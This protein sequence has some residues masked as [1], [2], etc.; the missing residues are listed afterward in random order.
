MI[1]Y[2]NTHGLK[3]G[4][5]KIKKIEKQTFIRSELLNTHFENPQKKKKTLLKTILSLSVKSLDNKERPCMFVGV[6]CYFFLLYLSF[7]VCFRLLVT[8]FYSRHYIAIYTPV[9]MHQTSFIGRNIYIYI[10]ISRISIRFCFVVVFSFCI[11]SISK[12]FKNY[13]QKKLYVRIKY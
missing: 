13:F 3:F 1:F 9:T 6:L 2:L 5:Y 7:Y 12:H 11:S 4:C 8:F 10:Y